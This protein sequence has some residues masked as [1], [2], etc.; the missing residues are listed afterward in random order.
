M[1]VPMSNFR[2]TC[3]ELFFTPWC[4]KP[5]AGK[6]K[7]ADYKKLAQQQKDKVCPLL[8]R[9]FLIVSISMRMRV[10]NSKGKSTRGSTSTRNRVPIGQCQSSPDGIL[11]RVFSTTSRL[12]STIWISSNGNRPRKW[13]LLL[14]PT[15]PY[16][17]YTQQHH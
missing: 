13:L 15:M 17:Q 3:I 14:H 12:S 4:I 2:N 9:G 5:V 16:T 8:F 11:T 6:S 7:G 1:R 10:S